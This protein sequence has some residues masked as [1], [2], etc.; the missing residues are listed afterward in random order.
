MAQETS[1]LKAESITVKALYV[2]DTLGR[3]RAS[4]EVRDGDRPELTLFDQNGKSRLVAGVDSDMAAVAL[5]DDQE[6]HRLVMGFMA[7]VASLV[8]NDEHGPRLCAGWAEGRPAFKLFDQAGKER[9]GIEL[10]DAGPC[11]GLQ[12]EKEQTLVGLAAA[13]NG[14]GIVLNGSSESNSVILSALSD[15]STAILSSKAGNQVVLVCGKKATGVVVQENGHENGLIARPT[16]GASSRTPSVA[17]GNWKD[18]FKGGLTSLSQT[19]ESLGV[20]VGNI[21]KKG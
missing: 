8:I 21:G 9:V 17:K 16:E 2:T 7:G 4:L 11:I 20:S 18:L 15:S 12:N 13:N 5:L 1:H 6:R 14:G 10:G 3:R 19:L